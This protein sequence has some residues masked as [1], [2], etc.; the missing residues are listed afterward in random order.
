[1]FSCEPLSINHDSHCLSLLCT[2][3]TVMISSG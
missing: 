3:L 1:M 2:V